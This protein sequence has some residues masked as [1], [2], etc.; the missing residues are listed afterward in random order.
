MQWK[1]QITSHN[2]IVH[3]NWIVRLAYSLAVL[4][5]QFKRQTSDFLEDNKFIQVLLLQI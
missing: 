1:Q 4:D 5:A 2:C 3:C